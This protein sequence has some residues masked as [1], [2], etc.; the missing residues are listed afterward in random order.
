MKPPTSIR[1]V[2]PQDDDHATSLAH[3]T[4][5]S[6]RS[7][8]PGTW[9]CLKTKAWVSNEKDVGGGFIPIRGY[10]SLAYGCFNLGFHYVIIIFIYIYKHIYIYSYEQWKNPGCL[11]C[12]GDEILPS[13]MGLFHKPL[14]IRITI[15]QPGFNGKVFFF[16][17]LALVVYGKQIW[18]IIPFSKWV[19]T[20]V[21]KSPKI[22]K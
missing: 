5:M 21:S 11:G 18:R 22:P 16:S 17:W 4:A 19:I 1:I 14:Y 10:C 12:I 6:S 15:N 7:W 13:Y 9:F 2:P 8:S 20:M 3:G